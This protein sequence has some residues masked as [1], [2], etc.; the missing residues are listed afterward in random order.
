MFDIEI[1][2][3]IDAPDK[4]PLFLEGDSFNV[5]GDF[6]ENSVDCIIT[7]PPYWGQRSYSS[8]GIGLE[9]NPGKYITD[10]LAIIGELKRVL[11]SSGSFWLNIGDT[12]DNKSLQGIPCRVAL[13]MIDDQKWILRNS[14]IWNKHKG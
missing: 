4:L 10:L 11:K 7:S 3:Y 6:P 5:L 12:F 2:E 13:K 14:V 1:R 9:D 8:G